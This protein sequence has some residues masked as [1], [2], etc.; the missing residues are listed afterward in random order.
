VSEPAAGPEAESVRAY[1]YNAR[2]TYQPFEVGESYEQD[3]FSSAMGRYR[4]FRERRAVED[5]LEHIAPGA[6]VLDCPCGTGR[7]WPLLLQRAGAI[8][9]MDLS[10]GML[11]HA[12]RRAERMRAPVEVL[13]GDA[14]EIPLGDA[15]VDWAFSY[16][17]TKHLPRPV[18][19]AVLREL[20]RVSRHGVIAS[21]LVVNHLTYEIWR[22]RYPTWKKLG[23]DESIPLLPEE[24]AT[25]AEH[26]G[27]ELEDMRRATTPIGTEFV[28][29]MRRRA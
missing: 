8:V 18:Q 29:L 21:F 28:C 27:L 17:L 5:L 6:T 1:D 9:A 15:S 10:A 22:R 12:R 16:A 20:A 25:M 26:A 14:E 13:E 7:W 19:Y 4:R 3:R 11:E 24:L 23:M 2:R